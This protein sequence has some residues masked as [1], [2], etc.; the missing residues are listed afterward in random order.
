MSYSNIQK[1]IRDMYALDISEGAITNIT[2]KLIPELRAWQQ[3][4][5]DAVYRFVGLDA[6]HYNIKDEGSYVNKAAYCTGIK[7]RGP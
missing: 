3:R 7:Y 4:L 2:D 6:I 1:H 5:L